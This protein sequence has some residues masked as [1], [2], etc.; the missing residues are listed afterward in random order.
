[1]DHDPA[2]IMMFLAVVRAGSVGAAAKLLKVT[3]PTVSRAVAKLESRLEGNR[4]FERTHAGMV[5]TDLGETLLPHAR[6][7]EAAINSFHRRTQNSPNEMS[8]SVRITATEGL[9]A[10]WLVPRLNELLQPYPG[11]TLEVSLDNAVF[12]LSRREA[13]LA[14]RLSQ[15][16]S[17]NLTA[18]HAALLSFQLF[19]SPSYV[20]RRGEPGTLDDFGNHSHVATEMQRNEKIVSWRRMMENSASEVLLT[21][22]AVAHVEAVRS[23]LGIGLLPSYVGRKYPDLVPVLPDIAWPKRAIWLVTHVELRRHA[24]IRLVIDLVTELFAKS[25]RDL[26][27][28]CLSRPPPTKPGLRSV[29]GSKA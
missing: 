4:V 20:E 18:T 7:V 21:N 25:A 3:P 19:A 24:R 11:L 23:G 1:M 22:S 27:E 15:P 16:T 12:D 8:G 13:D 26:S 9:G 28:P 5:L 10:L 29:T 2:E 6:D 17:A 14:L